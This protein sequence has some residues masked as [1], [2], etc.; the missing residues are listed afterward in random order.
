MLK[1]VKA[2]VIKLR[3]NEKEIMNIEQGI[4]NYE[5]KNHSIFDIKIS[6]NA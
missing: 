4:S 6:V 3:K 5:V 2:N 1:A